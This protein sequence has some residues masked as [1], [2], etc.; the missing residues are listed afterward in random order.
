MPD[1]RELIARFIADGGTITK[2]RY[3]RTAIPT[4]RRSHGVLPLPVVDNA[5]QASSPYYG[6]RRD[7][8]T[9]S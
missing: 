5:Y 2:G 9:V 4:I 3:Y 1:T 8:E 6:L 7:E